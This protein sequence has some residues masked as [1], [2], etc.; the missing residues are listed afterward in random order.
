MSPGTTGWGFA[1]CFGTGAIRTGRMPQSGA[2]VSCLTSCLQRTWLELDACTAAAGKAPPAG[3]GTFGVSRP[4]TP[5][6]T[7]PTSNP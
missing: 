2:E 3:R 4:T 6:W 5:A 7:R 1:S